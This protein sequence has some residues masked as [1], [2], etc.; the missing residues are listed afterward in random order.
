MAVVTLDSLNIRSIKEVELNNRRVLVRCDFNAP[1]DDDGIVTDDSRIV[2]ALPTLRYVLEQ[3]G[4]VICCSHLG[5][6]NGKRDP[7]FSLEPIGQRLGALLPDIDVMLPDDCVGDA[8]EHLI[9][10]QRPSQIILLENLRFHKGEK[11]NSEEFAKKLADRCDVYINDAFGALHREH[12][13]VSAL[14]GMIPD[15]AAGLLVEKELRFIGELAKGA[16]SPYLAIVGGA[17]ISGKIEVLEKLVDTVDG[18]IIGGAM[19]NTFLVARGHEMGRSLIEQDRIRLAQHLL[20]RFDSKGVKVL[21]PS[22]VICVDDLSADASTQSV[23][24]DNV[25]PEQMAVDIGPDSRAQFAAAIAGESSLGLPKTIF[26]N[27][28]MGV[29]EIE[30]FSQGT[31]AI[32]RALARSTARTIVGGGDSGAAVKKAGVSD[33]MTH[34]ST[35]GGASLSYLS[36]EA[37]PGLIAL[38]GGRRST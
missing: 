17:K 29:F 30:A 15:R 5:R 36:G 26:W 25:G 22:D 12:A 31:M 16:K 37:L 6:P 28:P 11:S 24:V 2:A 35:G 7:A 33:L 4:K 21:L 20:K 1:L 10:R 34:V 14:P 32:A 27:G 9:F 18:L 23:A 13:S 3:G 19:A 38:R 8:A